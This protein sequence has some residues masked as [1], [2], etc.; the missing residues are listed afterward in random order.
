MMD[1]EEQAALE[2]LADL[3]ATVTRLDETELQA[4]RREVEVLK[5]VLSTVM[6]TMDALLAR[7]TVRFNEEQEYVPV[8]NFRDPA[9]G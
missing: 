6:D 5:G 1:A 8:Q 4:L 9:V 3:E 2:S 7:E